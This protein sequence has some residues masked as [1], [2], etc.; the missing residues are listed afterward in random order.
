MPFS[1]DQFSNAADLERVDNCTTLSPNHI[2]PQ[3]LAKI[4]KTTMA[5]PKPNRLMP[6]SSSILAGA[7][8]DIVTR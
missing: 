1:T 3:A 4:I 7:I 6:L 2:C 5:L 8:D